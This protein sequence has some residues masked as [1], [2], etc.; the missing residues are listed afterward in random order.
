MNT[1]LHFFLSRLAGVIA[2]TL[3]PVVLTAFISMPLNL[4]HHPGE[5]ATAS[6]RGL[7]HMT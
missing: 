7:L 6:G 2:L 5:A 3:V 1:D 4:N